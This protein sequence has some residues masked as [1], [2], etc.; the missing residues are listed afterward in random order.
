MFNK[1]KFKQLRKKQK[2]SIDEISEMCG[3]A[4]STLYAYETG[5]AN[6]SDETLEKFSKI[7]KVPLSEFEE[8]E[9]TINNY[10][11]WKEEAYER[12]K[13]ENERLW[14]LV[15]KLTGAQVADLGKLIANRDTTK[16]D[17]PFSIGVTRLKAA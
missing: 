13:A 7:L 2:I 5:R 14:L 10:S 16:V 12:L 1:L 15:Q 17:L 3:I 4:P 9:E 8:K 6:P 11:N